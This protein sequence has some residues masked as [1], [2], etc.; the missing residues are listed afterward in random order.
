MA[1]MPVRTTSTRP[2]GCISEMN[3]ST[4]P[5]LPVS[6]KTNDRVGG[7]DHAGP[8]GIGKTQGLDAVVAGSRHLDQ[9]QLALDGIAADRQIRHR[10]NRHQALELAL[11]LLQH[12]RGAAGDDGDARDMGF[13]LG[14]RDGQGFDVV[15]APGEQADDPGEDARL[16][17]DDNRQGVRL[18]RILAV[19]EEIGRC[20]LVDRWL[21]HDV[22]LYTRTLPSAPIACSISSSGTS[23]PSSIS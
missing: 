22:P 2:S 19:L 16:V 14:L 23:S 9:R 17:V 5:V 15:A 6:S 8:E 4:L 11:D 18:D 20:R 10:M 1:A 7:I 12:H 3:C 21:G 13:V